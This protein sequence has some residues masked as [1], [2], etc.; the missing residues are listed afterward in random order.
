MKKMIWL[1][2]TLLSAAAASAQTL[3]AWQEGWFDI[4]HIATGKGECQFLIFPDGTTMVIDCGDTRGLGRGWLKSPPL[5]DS[6]LTPAAWAARYIDT[7]SPKPG[8]LD[9]VLISHF[10][11]D[12]MGES[13][14]PG[15]R[16]NGYLLAGISE[17]AEYEHFDLLVDRGYPSY[18]YPSVERVEKMEPMMKEYKKFVAYK[19]HRGDFRAER[20]E[21]GSRRQ[22]RTS[23]GK[24]DFEVWNVAG[25]LRVVTKGK[26][27][28]TQFSE[29]EPLEKFDENMFSCVQL[30]RYGPF[31]YYSGGDLPGGN[32]AALPFERDYESAVADLVGHCQVIKADHHGYRD[33]MNPYF[34]WKTAPEVVIVDASEASHPRRET[35]ERLTD[36]MYHAHPLIYTT[37]EAGREKMGEDAWAKIAGTGHI[38]VRVYEGGKSWQVFVLDAT[39][40][41]YPVLQASE[42][43]QTARQ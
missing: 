2:A 10:H 35:V 14:A 6:T 17:L 39:S 22:F 15:E 21:P 26:K 24:R 4:H 38:V 9:Y 8:K 1:L 28:R 32:L 23:A 19:T 12:H 27:T 5:P 3:P 40:P 29:G 16:M 7:F 36:P 20:F 33:S 37:S 25:A 18:D 34:L 31:K 13:H 11:S 42:I 41:D 30:F 43:Y